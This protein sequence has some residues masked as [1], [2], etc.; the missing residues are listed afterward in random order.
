MLLMPECVEDYIS[1]DNSVRVIDAYIGSLELNALG[2]KKAEL[3]E[4]GRPPYAPQDLLKLYLYGY[5][6]RIRSSRRLESETKRNLEVI[7]LLKKLSPDHKTIAR[8]RC[9]NPDALK[10]VFK[11]FVKMCLGLGLYGRELAAIDGS[12]FK[13]VNSSERNFSVEEL[14][15]RIKRLNS[16][17]DEYMQQLKE[18]DEAEDGK[19]DNAA[20]D[21]KQIVERLSN[22]KS[23][24]ESYLGEMSEN[25]ETQK[26]LTDP[27]ARLMKGANAFEVSYNVQTAVDSKHK[28]IAEFDVTNDG[29]DMKQ[30]ASMAAAASEILEAPNITATADT[31]YNSASEIV[32][33]IEMGITPHVAGSEGSYCVPCK[34]DEAEKI[35]AHE[36]GKG[37]YIKERN[38]VICPM[39]KIMPPK[40]YKK[41]GRTGGYYNY[42]ACSE[43]VCRCTKVKYRTFAV[44]M[45]KS[46]FSKIHNIE[47]LHIKQI[48]VKP[49]PAII[50][51][52]KTIVEHP[53][54]TIKRAMDTQY[55]L[56]SGIQKA[57]GEFSLVFLAYN[58]KRVIN[59]VGAK[60][61]LMMMGI[62][63]LL[64]IFIFFG[65]LFQKSSPF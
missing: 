57:I 9:D 11:N 37:I 54:G 64:A 44:R 60:R 61:L 2:F 21:I 63:S 1:E 51:R 22:R 35:V 41:S 10:N 12:K 40:F 4:T 58:L 19:R 16:R 6:N 55:L 49:N 47:N 45:K 31:G 52:R 18:A 65:A 15:E 36:N 17:I 13:A 8:F 23:T 38:I 30:L 5:M 26:S 20:G 43:C 29:N 32:R 27:D 62:P 50:D 39:G 33:C 42:R 7:W 46:E 25:G 53:F 3:S 28:L 48:Y 56:M 34:E 24:Y 59:I 14:N